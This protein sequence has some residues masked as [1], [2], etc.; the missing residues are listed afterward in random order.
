MYSSFIKWTICDQPN[1]SNGFAL[2]EVVESSVRR[3]LQSSN[4]HKATGL[5]GNLSR[6]L[7]GSATAISEP[8][9]FIIN[10]PIDSVMVPENFK[11]GKVVPDLYINSTTRVAQVIYRPFVV[12]SQNME[13]IIYDQLQFYLEGHNIL[14]EH[15]SG[16]RCIFSTE[17]ALIYVSD[18]VKSNADKGK[19]TCMLFIG[20]LKVKPHYF[21]SKA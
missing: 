4:P 1:K 9:A 15:Q 18:L 11:E 13:R 10:L 8:I 20:P 6:F 21:T 3:L 14:Y 17:T 2:S 12:L 7:R 19:L 16:F 5:G